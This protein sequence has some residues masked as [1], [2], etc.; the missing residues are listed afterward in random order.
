MSLGVIANVVYTK[1][2]A[3]VRGWQDLLGYTNTSLLQPYDNI[4]DPETGKPTTVFS[5]S[6]YKIANYEQMSGMKDWTYNPIEDLNKEMVTTENIQSR[7]GGTL[8][9]NIIEG[10]NIETGGMWTRGNEVR[11]TLYQRDAYRIRLQYNDAT[12]KAN[13]RP[14]TISRTAP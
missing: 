2:E 3:P 9:V 8:R 14:A 10:L 6:T 4:V 7:I 11:Q 13:N 12:S 5:T 1:D